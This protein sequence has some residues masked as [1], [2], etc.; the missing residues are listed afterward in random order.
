MML[1]TISTLLAAGLATSVAADALTP[2]VV[3][4]DFRKERVRREDFPHIGRR[5]SRRANTVQ[6]DL[7]NELSLY[8]INV[9]CISVH[10]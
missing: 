8:I 4:F 5:H 3:G 2:G 9:S 1:N 7:S 10:A 6:A